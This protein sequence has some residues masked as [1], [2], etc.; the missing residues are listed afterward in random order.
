MSLSC[1][2]LNGICRFLYRREYKKFIR[3]CDV[4]NVQRK[5][6]KDLLKKNTGTVYGKKYGFKNIKTYE[7]FAR[8]V[9]I[10]VYEDYEPYINAIADGEKLVLTK[11]EVRLFEVTSGS[12]GGKKLIPYTKKLKS[13]FQK[14]I[15]PWLYNIYASNFGVSEGKSY[16]SITPVT[17]EKT[18]S[19]AGI[20]IGFEEDTEYF[21]FIEQF[22]MKKIFAV[23]SKVKFSCD[24]Q[25]FYKRTTKQLLACEELTLISVWNP[26]FLSLLC[27]FICEH[28]DELVDE[29]AEE[30][31]NQIKEAVIENR[32]DRV[33]PMLKIISCWADGSA[34]DYLMDLQK[35]FPTVHLQPK[36][37]LATECFVSFPFLEEEGSRLSIH[38][39]FFE[40]R[41]VSDGKIVL[42][43]ELEK[44]EYE[45]IVTTGGGFYRYCLFDIVEVLE[46]FSDHPPRL[47]FKRRSGSTSDLFGEKLTEEFVQNVC[48]KL[49]IEEYFCLLVPE[50]SGYCFYTTATNVTSE[51][52]EQMLRGSYHYNYCRQLGQ[53]KQVRVVEVL[54]DPR[55]SYIQK[56][57]DDGM[58]MG[59]IK[60]AYLTTKKGWE[61]YFQIR[62]ER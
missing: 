59:D 28:L 32:F 2:V 17:S 12:S 57:V 10:T 6:L 4:E 39:H 11:E 47:K 33:F 15:K 43:N 25:D 42:A 5:Y 29:C 55:R 40:F 14:G 21:G 60:P 7:D 45:V 30:R 20:P 8:K 54:G 56:L 50:E 16:W 38:S 1:R 9:P 24:M 26:T 46:V 41:K 19:K 37:L 58:R 61:N 62:K 3:S 35:R 27:D 23:D 31:A 48:Q 22:I 52:F 49:G 13:E 44:G 53:L 51:D 34:K 18:Y 36:G